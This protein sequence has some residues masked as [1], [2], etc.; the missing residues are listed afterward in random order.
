M[1]LLRLPLAA[2]L[3]SLLALQP[4]LAAGFVI[5]PDP[6][7]PTLGEIVDRE[8]RARLPAP[9]IRPVRSQPYVPPGATTVWAPGVRPRGTRVR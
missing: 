8:E 3:F 4:A 7:S 6:G 5:D 9:P 1:R 2:G